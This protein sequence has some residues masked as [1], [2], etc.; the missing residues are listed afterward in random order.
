MKKEN[1]PISKRRK[2]SRN[3]RAPI[4]TALLL[5][6]ACAATFGGF[7]VARYAL[8][9]AGKSALASAAEFYFTSDLLKDATDIPAYFIDPGPGKFAI[10]LY[11]YEDSK[12]MTSKDIVYT[13]T[14]ENGT[15][16]VTGGKQ[17]DPST[18]TLPGN[19]PQEAIITVT[20]SSA[21][22][23]DSVRVTVSSSEPYAK[24][25]RAEFTLALENQY[26]VEDE[27]GKTAAV[28]IMTCADDQ[29]DIL[30]KLPEGVIPDAADPRVQ[31][32]SGSNEYQ[33][34]S[35]GYGIY[36]LVLLKKEKNKNLSVSDVNFANSIELK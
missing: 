12:R 3:K 9:Q 11:N 2:P 27:A 36:S 21:N 6:M 14:V 35:P 1:D 28:L 32:Q 10:K 19:Q 4:F 17:N 18:Y 25:L 23:L 22:N 13:V 16:A 7:T 33:F 24:I 20:P 5:T 26:T 29:K 15:A 30:L 8:N 31:K 34:H